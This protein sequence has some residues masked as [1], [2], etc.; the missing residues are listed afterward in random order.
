MTYVCL[1]AC[2]G[3]LGLDPSRTPNCLASRPAGSS[4]HNDESYGAALQSGT[5]SEARPFRSN[6]RNYCLYR[7]GH[8]TA[9]GRTYWRYLSEYYVELQLN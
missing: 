2:G 4:I 6:L 7:N 9:Y 8:R 3:R 5:G 1:Q